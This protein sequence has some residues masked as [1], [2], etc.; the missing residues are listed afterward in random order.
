MKRNV[1]EDI[2]DKNKPVRMTKTPAIIKFYVLETRIP[3]LFSNNI[4]WGLPHHT[5]LRSVEK[6]SIC[7]E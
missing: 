5:P 1:P 2:E 4:S 7:K 3:E 6:W